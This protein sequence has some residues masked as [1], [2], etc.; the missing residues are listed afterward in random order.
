MKFTFHGG[1]EEVGRSC[2]EVDDRFLFDA[3]LKITEEGSE[4]PIMEDCNHIKAVF[5]S[6]SHLDHCGALPLFNKRGLNC[7]IFCNSMTRQTS[8][9][10][11]KDS[12]HIELINKQHPIYTKDNLMSVISFMKNVKFGRSYNLDDAKFSFHYAG[13]IPGASSVLLELDNR[14]ILYTGDYNTIDTNLMSGADMD[15][16][17]IDVLICESTYGDREHPGRKLEEKRFLDNIKKVLERGG[18]VLIPTFAVGR[19]QEIMEMLNKENFGVP[20]YLD[21]MA[22]RVTNLYKKMPE[23]IKNPKKYTDAINKV[24]FIKKWKDRHE[25]VKH[26][27]IIITT[28]GMLDGG[29]VIDYLGYFYH[30]EKNG[31]FLTGYQGEGSNG[32]L[33]LEEGKVFLDGVRVKMKAQ[34]E[35]FDFSAHAGRRE[36]IKT[37]NSISPKNLILQHGDLEP[38]EHLRKEFESK[39]NVYVPKIGESLDI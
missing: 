33:L 6:H 37:I 7:G 39:M 10:L 31:V 25:V 17:D 19:A 14:K 26:Q 29:P 12:F 28:S 23:Y 32:R 36:I 22:K 13:H 1:A 27:S 9:I 2:I 30:N 4:Y 35:K 20:I 3:G 8:K 18:N 21:G 24:K 16:K 15:F 34:V 5:L 38:L 11:M